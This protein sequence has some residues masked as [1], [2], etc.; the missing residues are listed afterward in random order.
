[1]DA[2]AVVRTS[3]PQLRRAQADHVG[4]AQS[5]RP[6]AASGH[7]IFRQDQSPAE[8]C[9]VAVAKPTT[10]GASYYRRAV[11]RSRNPIPAPGDRSLADHPV[12]RYRSL[13]GLCPST[14]T[15]SQPLAPTEPFGPLDDLPRACFAW[16][17]DR[18]GTKGV[19]PFL[20]SKTG[21]P[22]SGNG[23]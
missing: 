6:L 1:M 16:R 5:A 20:A 4:S 23:V 2:S 8:T 22:F 10:T 7:H 9:T 17:Q 18:P 21:K 13:A 19:V 15:H 12:P 11:P 3:S 14:A